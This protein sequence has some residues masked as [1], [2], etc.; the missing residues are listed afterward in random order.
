MRESSTYFNSFVKVEGVPK[1]IGALSAEQ[2]R[3]RLSSIRIVRAGWFGHV[4]RAEAVDNQ[5]RLTTKHSIGTY[6]AESESVAQRREVQWTFLYDDH[7]HVA[8]EEGYDASGHR[9]WGFIYAPDAEEMHVRLAH[10][11]GADGFP[12]QTKEYGAG[13]VRIEYS[14]EGYESTVTYRNA[15][16]EPRAGL[17]HAFGR[18]YTFDQR[19]RIVNMVSLGPDGK[20][21]IDTAGNAGLGMTLDELGNPVEYI[22]TDATGAVTTMRDGW[23][24]ARA[25]YDRYG[26]EI[27]LAFFDEHDRPTLHKDGYSRITPNV[28][29]TGATSPRSGTGTPKTSRRLSTAATACA[30]RTTIG[31][32]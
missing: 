8:H 7:G 10:F 25:K 14:P 6:L 32:T 24:K 2:V 31:P 15:L 13:Y 17:D 23:S 22:A 16:G 11:V 3:H 29:T 9:V 4:R 28:T 19:G 26:N 18:Q 20:P 27:E 1:G 5:F 30:T 21:M 12:R